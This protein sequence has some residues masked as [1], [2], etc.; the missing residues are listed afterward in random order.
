MN[1]YHAYRQTQ[2]QTAAPG[3]LVVML[4]RGAVRFVSAAAEA[5]ENRDV[6]TA[7]NNLVRAQAIVSELCETLD[8][9]RGGDLARN[10]QAIYEYLSRRLIDANLHKD[11]A[12]AREVERFLRD[13]LPAWEQAAREAAAARVAPAV[14]VAA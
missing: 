5:I 12:A 13:L 11:A 8:L 7:H 14:A 9:E 10:L 1:G 6:P 2:A 3:E 4:Y